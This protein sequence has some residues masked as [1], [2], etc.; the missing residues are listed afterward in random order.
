[1]FCR[2]DDYRD[3]RLVSRFCRWCYRAKGWKWFERVN[4]GY[5]LTMPSHSA[6]ETW[7]REHVIMCPKACVLDDGNGGKL[8]FSFT[9][10]KPPVGCRYYFEHMTL[11]SKDNVE[12]ESL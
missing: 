2:R 3:T 1:M 9:V 10:D 12:Q 4:N 8:T 7:V 6:E 5:T 11:T